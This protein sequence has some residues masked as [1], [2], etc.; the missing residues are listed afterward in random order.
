MKECGSNLSDHLPVI[1]EFTCDV[2]H[3][4]S[5]PNQKAVNSKKQQQYLRWDKADLGKY[6]CVTGDQLQQ[7]LVYFN[8]NMS[9]ANVNRDSALVFINNVYSELVKILREASDNNVP[10]KAKKFYKFWW[11]QELDVLKENSIRE[12]II[13]KDARRPRSGSIF[14]AY[15]TSKLNYKRR[16][17]EYERQEKNGLYQ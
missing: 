3:V 9:Y 14:K 12:D 5:G 13:W 1:V 10:A 2:K 8:D 17:R 16:M 4:L 15:Q 6:Y 11:C 7:L